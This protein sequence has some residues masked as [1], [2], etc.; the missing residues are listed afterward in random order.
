MR[1]IGFIILTFSENRNLKIR[2]PNEKGVC[3]DGICLAVFCGIVYTTIGQF[4]C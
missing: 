4:V 3:S 1:T 2:F